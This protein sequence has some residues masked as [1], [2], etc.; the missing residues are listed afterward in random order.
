MRTS[1]FGIA[2]AATLL[3]PAADGAAQ[4]CAG[5]H[6]GHQAQAIQAAPACCADHAK[7][8]QPPAPPAGC[9][10]SIEATT[11]PMPCCDMPVADD[12]KVAAAGLGLSSPQK[13]MEVLFRDPVRVGDQVLMGWYVIEHDDDRMAR[14]EPCTHIY[15][16][17]TF[18]EPV[19]TFHCTHL[20]RP[21]PA[22]ATVVL[23][24]TINPAIKALVEFQFSGESASHG[25]PS[26]R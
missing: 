4:C 11:T 9:C 15:E 12:P 25:V 20:E 23:R 16:Y 17:D 1:L 5:E 14:G 10:E 24:P 19:A 7:H 22:T 13:L 3:V 8:A 18:S 2:I 21:A 26:V 6:A